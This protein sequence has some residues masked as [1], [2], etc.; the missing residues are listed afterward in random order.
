MQLEGNR[1]AAG[2]RRRLTSRPVAFLLLALFFGWLSFLFDRE[3]TL[4]A[5]TVV[6]LPGASSSVLRR[7][8]GVVG[9]GVLE[10]HRVCGRQA[11][12]RAM[13]TKQA[14]RTICTSAVL[15]VLWLVGAPAVPR[16]HAQ[17]VPVGP[18]PGGGAGGDPS[19]SR[20]LQRGMPGSPGLGPWRGPSPA[21]P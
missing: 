20:P 8:T 13:E 21:D 19:V 7:E 16:L 3:A 9:E 4:L 12:R 1:A 17:P 15:A 10:I 5:M 14:R 18:G 6:W 2:A 11:R